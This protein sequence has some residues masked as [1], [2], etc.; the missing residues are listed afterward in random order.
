MGTRGLATLGPLKSKWTANSRF[1]LTLSGNF[2]LPAFD[3]SGNRVVSG[4]GVA[5]LVIAD[6]V[7]GT[8]RAI[9]HRD[10]EGIL[11]AQWSARDDSVVFGFGSFFGARDGG[12][13]VA[14]IQPD[15]SGFRQ[16]T[17]GPN[18]NGFPSVA[19]DGKHIVYRT[20][21]ADGQGLRI[22][23][24]ETSKVT[25]LTLD[26]DN[27]PIWSPRGDLIVFVRQYMGDYEMFSIKPDGT[28]LRRLTAS[29]G[30]DGHAAFSPDGEWIVFSSSR[31]GFKD[32][33]LYS[34]NSQ[35]YGELF[36]MRYDGTHIERLTDNQWE[37]AG[38]AWR[39]DHG[40]SVR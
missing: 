13:Q 37:D 3:K 14:V 34:D 25:T 40:K 16:L 5:D 18:D 38:P 10:G 27:F 32:E 20:F 21:G 1:E 15:G 35:P 28:S 9:F 23:D 31:M 12:A 24:L 36:V 4:T 6:L 33:A 26:Y 2:L 19:P 22:M 30:N 11:G 8:S 7:S 29:Q 39:I 17:S